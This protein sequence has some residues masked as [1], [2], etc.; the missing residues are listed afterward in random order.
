MTGD[1][2]PVTLHVNGADHHLVVESRRTLA[3]VLREDLGLTGTHLGCEHGVCGACTVAVDGEAVR[4]CLLLAVQAAGAAIET[5]E[6]L[7][8]DGELHP[9]QQG[10]WDSHAFQC[11][12]CAAGFLMTTKCLLD[13]NPEPTRAEIRDELSGNLCRCTGYAGIIDGVEAAAAILAAGRK[14]AAGRA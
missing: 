7:A 1:V 2:Q 11:A 14:A 8:V 13:R 10:M 12:F 3:D 4:A 9:V 6:S 5:V